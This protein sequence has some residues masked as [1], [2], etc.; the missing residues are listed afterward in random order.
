[1]LGATYRIVAQNSTGVALAAG[2]TITIKA[3]RWKLTSAGAR[4]A[5]ATEATLT[6]AGAGNSL[7]SAGF[8]LGTTQDNSTDGYFGVELK[9]SVTI[10]TATP[11]G[12]VNFYMQTSTDG[13]TTWPD[14]GAGELLKSI[15]FTAVGTKL[16][17]Y[18]Y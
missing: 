13:G 4:S 18:V 7:A 14:S 8:V 2:D 9:L 15:A 1:M 11:N 12:Y 10:S 3:K 16:D 5:E 6:A 17:S